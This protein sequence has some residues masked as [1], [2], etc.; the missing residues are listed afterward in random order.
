VFIANTRHFFLERGYHAAKGNRL[1][2]SRGLFYYSI[3]KTKII[4]AHCY[5]TADDPTAGLFIKD[6]MLERFGTTD[7]TVMHYPFGGNMLYSKNVIKLLWYL[8]RVAK[9]V[10]SIN[11]QSIV[12]AHWWI[13]IGWLAARSQAQVEVICHGS[14]IYWLRK[15][16]LIAKVFSKYVRRVQRWTFVSQDLKTEFLR[17]Y[18]FVPEIVMTVE[19][20]PVN[21]GVFERSAVAK[22]KGT[23]VTCGA[24]IL[25]KNVDLAIWYVKNEN[26]RTGVEHTLYVIGEGK[27]KEELKNLAR[28]LRVEVV[29]TGNVLPE[30]VAEIFNI[31]ETFLLFSDDEGYGQVIDEAKLCGCRTIVTTGD[32]KVEHADVILNRPNRRKL[33]KI[34]TGYQPWERLSAETSTD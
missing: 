20:M 10:K 13:P 6:W 3:M 9:A 26:L 29:F 31:C 19:H 7:L 33:N 12:Y 24:L 25:R 22:Q 18:P 28:N 2:K 30:R 34:L 32:G 21:T 8:Y 15:H 11:S 1:D 4:L 16:R 5:P 27:L 14:D 23:F 17:L